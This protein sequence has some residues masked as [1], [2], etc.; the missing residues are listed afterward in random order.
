MRTYVLA[1]PRTHVIRVPSLAREKGKREQ[2]VCVSV[3]T[4]AHA[5]VCAH[6]VGRQAGFQRDSAAADTG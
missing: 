1:M 2:R 4:R 6:I 3:R 5:C